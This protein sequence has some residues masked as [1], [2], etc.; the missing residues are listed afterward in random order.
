MAIIFSYPPLKSADVAASDK[1][2]I[3]KMNTD[4][5]PTK[6]I[7]ISELS[8]AIGS[9]TA[10]GGPFLP[11]TAGPTVPLTGDLYMAPNG[12]GPSVGSKNIV[13][14]GID[15]TGTELNAAQIHTVDSSINPSGQDLHFSNA[16]DNGIMTTNLVVDAFGAVG[17][18][19]T[20]PSSTLDVNGNGN[21][22]TTLNVGGNVQFGGATDFRYF[23]GSNSIGLG[24]SSPNFKMDISGG[25][26]RFE[27]NDGIRFGGTGSNN[28]NWRIYTTGTNTGTLEIG[29]PVSS[30]RLTIY[31]SGLGTPSVEGKVQFNLYGS[32]NFTGTAAYDLS[33]DSS[34]NIIEKATRKIFTATSLDTTTNYNVSPAGTQTPIVWD[35]ELIKDSIYTH[36]NAV[37]PEQ[38]TVTEAGTYRIYSMLTATSTGQRVQIL[39]RIA[40]NGTARAR[41][42]AGMY[43]RSSS[44][45]NKSSSII[46]ETIVLNANDIITITGERG[47]STSTA[48]YNISEASYFSIE[49]I[50]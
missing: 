31:K 19:T 29:N 45:Q 16:N 39:L 10:T 12:A 11:L 42:G 48:T 4:G 24:T 1:L 38:V 50:A 36:D 6:T 46:E 20:S 37:N 18:G 9:G 27:N 49:K 43:I 40:I 2:I 13:F 30:P 17:I 26:L 7:T 8:K 47:S 41:F 3:S 35:S 25:D 5:N 23:V 21:F 32:G 22:A 34:G 28:T 44:G 15:D 14:R 33:V